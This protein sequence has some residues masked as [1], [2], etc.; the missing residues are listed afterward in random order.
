MPKNRPLILLLVI[1]LALFAVNLAVAGDPGLEIEYP[2]LPSVQTPN[3]VRTI[4]PVYVIY[5]IHLVMMLS[6]LIILGS[7]LYAGFLYMTSSGNPAALKNSKDRMLSSFLGIII[8]FSS[9]LIFQT[10]NPNL[11][12]LTITGPEYIGGVIFRDPDAPEGSQEFAT[13]GSVADFGKLNMQPETVT[14]I[15]TDIEVVPCH[16]ENNFEKPNCEDHPYATITSDSTFP[17]DAKAAKLIWKTPGIYLS[18]Q[19]DLK[20]DLQ[21]YT[22]S[23]GSLGDF[24]NKTQ[25]IF[26]QEPKSSSPGDDRIYGVILHEDEGFGGGCLVFYNWNNP[27]LNLNFDWKNK[28]SS[29][30][31]FKTRTSWIGGGGGYAPYP[32]GP[33]RFYSDINYLGNKIGGDYYSTPVLTGDPLMGW[34]PAA[35]AANIYSLKTNGNFLVALAGFNGSDDKCE[36]FVNENDS[37]LSD[38]PMGQCTLISACSPGCPNIWGWCPVCTGSCVY[39]LL[40]LPLAQ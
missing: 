25:S 38:N 18:S 29:I 31:V 35:N 11:I 34:V 24:N 3:T 8:L 6:G 7:L 15:S 33:V 22:N 32:G 10:I 39:S 27:K 30:T 40:V 20:G 36:V 23:A 17:A 14:F 5:I 16:D 9:Y 19:P 2:N 37:D 13:T 26:I 12:E 1:V 21:I 4:L 28:V